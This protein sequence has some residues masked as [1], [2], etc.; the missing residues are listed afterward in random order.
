MIKNVT[1]AALALAAVPTAAQAQQS[2]SGT[3]IEIFAGID[4]FKDDLGREN[5]AFNPERERD[6]N[7]AI[8]AGVGYDFVTGD[9]LSVGVDVEY[10]HSTAE[11]PVFV[12]GVRAGD[13]KYGSE[14]YGGGRVTFAVSPT[15]AL[16]GKIGYSYLDTEYTAQALNNSRDQNLGGIRGALG[17]QF[18]GG[19]DDRTYYGLEG[20]YTNYERGLTRKGLLLVVGHRF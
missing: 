10:V 3:R 7:A 15:V 18:R 5:D 11:L 8:G 14:V 1:L 13:Q 20:R 2:A 16:V 4:D 9:A 19:D 6:I 17:V 12:N